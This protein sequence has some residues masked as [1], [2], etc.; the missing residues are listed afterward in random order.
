M[1]VLIARGIGFAFLIY[2]IAP[3]LSIIKS[4]KNL[5]KGELHGEASNERIVIGPLTQRQIDRLTQLKERSTA[6]HSPFQS[7]TKT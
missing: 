3:L 4:A 2:L 7:R 1:E 6:D 5:F